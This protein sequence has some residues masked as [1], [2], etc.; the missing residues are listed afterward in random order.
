MEMF[1]FGHCPEGNGHSF[2]LS[3][4]AWCGFHLNVD[5]SEVFWPKEDPRSRLTSIF[6]PNFARPMHG[7][8]L[9]SGPASVD[10]NFCNEL[11]MKRVAKT[12]RLMDAIVKINDPQYELFLLHSCTGISKLYF[13]MRTCPLRF[14]ESA[15][16][17]FDMAL[18]SSL[19]RIVTAFGLG[20]GDWKWRL[21]T[22]PFAFGEEGA[23]CLFCG[24]GQTMNGKTYRCVLCYRLGIP[25]FFGSKPC[26]ASLKVFAWDIYGDHAVSCAGTIGIKHHHNVVRDT[27]VDICYHSGISTGK[28]V[29]I[30][31]D[32]G[33]DEPLRPT[34]I[35]LYSW[36]GGLDVCVDLTGSSPLTQTGLVDFVPELEADDVTLLKWIWKFSITQDIKAR[37]KTNE[38]GGD[39]LDNVKTD[40]G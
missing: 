24:L 5:K 13:T 33:R 29:N 11:V 14:F 25:L 28:E 3:L 18:C 35:L 34:N 20:F 21:S 15:Q 22:L 2:S 39:E 10:I 17:S 6:P 19:E 26:S 7:V 31:L 36:D 40:G 27:L 23:W 16:R 8:K 4:H 1:P 38:D 30:R 9:L 32:K 37:K 12:I